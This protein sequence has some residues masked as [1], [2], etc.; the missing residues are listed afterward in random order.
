ML[1]QIIAYENGDLSP[2]GVLRL[3]AQLIQSGQAWTLQGH[4]GRQAE[5]FID[6]GLISPDGQLNTEALDEAGIEMDVESEPMSFFTSNIDL[7][8]DRFDST[9]KLV[10]SVTCTEENAVNLYE[11]QFS[12]STKYGETFTYQIHNSN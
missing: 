10:G 5:A 2:A 4:Y 1:N 7:E 6:F 11:S 9:G 3:F 12:A 8:L